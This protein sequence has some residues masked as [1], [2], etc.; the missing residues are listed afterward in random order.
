MKVFLS[1]SGPLSKEIAEL[2][3]AWLKQVIQALDPFVSS[4]DIEKG[5]QW[6][7]EISGALAE[8]SFGI[9][10]LTSQNMRA[11]W[12]VFEAGCL[13]KGLP[14]NRVATLLIDINHSDVEMPLAAF[15]GTMAV[16]EDMLELV[17]SLNSQLVAGQ[18]NQA[19]LE[20]SFRKWWPDFES[21]LA[22]AR[23]EYRHQAEPA[24]IN[25]KLRELF[26]KVSHLEKLSEYDNFSPQVLHSCEEYLSISRGEHGEYRR[27]EFLERLS[28]NDMAKIQH[29]LV[30]MGRFEEV[31][32]FMKT[33]AQISTARQDEEEAMTAQGMAANR[34]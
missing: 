3:Q 2:L 33:R 20:K 30:A 10:C 21:G 12:L 16:E 19:E 23:R 4:H 18:L 15:N 25:E 22:R 27:K 7:S 28:D 9:L 1:W 32:E 29:C 6:Y 24:S 26:W 14:S 31:Q 8:T 17:K 11:P 34:G 13:Y 5:S